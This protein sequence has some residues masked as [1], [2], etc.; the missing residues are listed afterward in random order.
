MKGN[1]LTAKLTHS[2][3]VGADRALSHRLVLVSEQCYVRTPN[4]LSCGWQIL[5]QKADFPGHYLL[6]MPSG[7]MKGC[8]RREFRC[9]TACALQK[10]VMDVLVPDG[11][12]LFLP[13]T[14]GALNVEK[15]DR[16]ML[17]MLTAQESDRC[18]RVARVM[19]HAVQ[20]LVART[21]SDQSNHDPFS[22]A[23]S[24]R[25]SVCSCRNKEAV[26]KLRTST[27]RRFPDA[28]L[29][30]SRA[31]KRPQKRV[32]WR[33]WTQERCIRW[34][35]LACKEVELSRRWRC[36]CRIVP[37]VGLW[38]QFTKLLDERVRMARLRLSAVA[39]LSLPTQRWN[40]TDEFCI[41][42]QD[43]ARTS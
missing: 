21:F 15:S 9:D 6:P 37:V 27:S 32:G 11:H 22:K 30:S 42:I 25:N 34:K 28:V 8:L 1:A 14:T 19:I 7:N 33:E 36:L 26:P 24:S 18:N 35:T 12:R 40:L 2:K 41:G 43:T 5:S 13:S 3:V 23:T 10:R 29:L 16:D 31:S 38:A 20:T 39:D 4:W 17:G